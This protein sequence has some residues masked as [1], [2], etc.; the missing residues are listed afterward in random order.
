MSGISGT[1]DCLEH[2]LVMSASL[3]GNNIERAL[4]LL[5]VLWT[6][7]STDHMRKPGETINNFSLCVNFLAVFS[8]LTDEE[9]VRA[10]TDGLW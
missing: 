10:G 5:H 9:R 7:A 8:L 4:N 3:F 1:A 2:W 6:G